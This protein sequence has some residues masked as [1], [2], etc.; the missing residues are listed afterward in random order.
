MNETEVSMSGAAKKTITKCIDQSTSHGLPNIFNGSNVLIR[1]GRLLA[2]LTC[3]SVACY[4]I[5]QAFITYYKYE[6]IVAINEIYEAPTDFPAVTICNLNT[7]AELNIDLSIPGKK[8][9]YMYSIYLYNNCSFDF[10]TY[11]QNIYEWMVCFRSTNITNE[12]QTLRVIENS[13]N[14]KVYNE[15]RVNGEM[16]DLGWRYKRDMRISDTF[17]N[18][19]ID[20]NITEFRHPQYGNCYT[21]NDENTGPAWTTN[22]IGRDYGLTLE[23]QVS[24]GK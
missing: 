13:I 6:T 23:L 3:L 7:V 15:D 20:L 11:W 12:I 21:F 16:I 22:K 14:S 19:P 9:V 2:F 4:F 17:N 8:K 10:D 1:I 18:A 24:H 5:A